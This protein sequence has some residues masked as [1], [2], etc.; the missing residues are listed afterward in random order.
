VPVVL[1]FPHLLWAGEEYQNTVLGLETPDSEKH[2]FAI[3]FE[4]TVG[5]PLKGN[6]R[7]QFNTIMRPVSY[8]GLGYFPD[9]KKLPRALFPLLWIEDKFELTDKLIDELNSKLLNNLIIMDAV[10]WGFI[11]VG[12]FLAILSIGFCIFYKSRESRGQ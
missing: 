5:F 8:P 9:T 12:I 11:A 6:I 1:S 10:K 7:I 3:E 4:P 2:A